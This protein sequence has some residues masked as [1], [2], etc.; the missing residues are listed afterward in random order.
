[1]A[2][3]EAGGAPPAPRRNPGTNRAA[4]LPLTP[5]D[6]LRHQPAGSANTS[7][8]PSSG[9]R[10]RSAWAPLS[11]PSTEHR[12]AGARTRGGPLHHRHDQRLPGLPRH[13]GQGRRDVGADEPFY[14]EATDWRA[15]ATLTERERA[16][17][18]FAERFALDHLAMDDDFWD[19][20]HAPVLGGRAGRP[21]HLLRHVPRHG[22]GA[23]RGRRACSRR[24]H[25]LVSVRATAAARRIWESAERA[26][27]RGWIF[28]RYAIWYQPRRRWPE[29]SAELVRDLVPLE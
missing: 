5:M 23:R 17:A 3:W 12:A 25:R 14:A 16:A 10:W 20:M 7:T 24:A 9:P 13:P 2:W 19:R 11:R 15:A 18:E 22:P 4:R 28:E 26:P 1:M 6:G 21:H 8:G 29:P 27:R